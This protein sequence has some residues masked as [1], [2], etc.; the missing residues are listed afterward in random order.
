M[1]SQSQDEESQSSGLPYSAMLNPFSDPASISRKKFTRNTHS[2]PFVLVLVRKWLSLKAVVLRGQVRILAGSSLKKSLRSH[3]SDHSQLTGGSSGHG[4]V[5]QSSDT[6]APCSRLLQGQR[7][8]K[9]KDAGS[10]VK[11]ATAGPSNRGAQKEP[12]APVQAYTVLCSPQDDLG[13]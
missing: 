13:A 7:S 12:V 3:C 1:K 8:K 5:E 2:P 4:E 10:S 11:T 9:V 6:K